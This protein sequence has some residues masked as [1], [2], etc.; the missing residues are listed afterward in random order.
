MV[1]TLTDVQRNSLLEE[2]N[3]CDREIEECLLASKTNA[4][5]IVGYFDW[6]HEKELIEKLISQDF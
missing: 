4:W 5:A 2:V 6:I 1:K 3:R